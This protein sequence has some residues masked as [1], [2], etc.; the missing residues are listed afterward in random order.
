MGADDMPCRNGRVVRQ[1]DELQQKEADKII[2]KLCPSAQ[3]L[4]PGAARQHAILNM[5]APMRHS[6]GISYSAYTKHAFAHT[7]SCT[8]PMI[9]QELDRGP[10]SRCNPVAVGALE[11]FQPFRHRSPGT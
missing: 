5:N 8:A 3:P 6:H 11:I 7:E 2:R 10:S 4:V 9:A 1:R